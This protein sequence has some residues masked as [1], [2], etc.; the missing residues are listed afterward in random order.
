MSTA[1]ITLAPLRPARDLAAV[2]AVYRRAGDYLALE[3]GLT[4]AAAAR[5][6]F[7]ERPPAGSDEPM[8]FGI[9]GE[10]GL[11]AIGDLAFGYPQPDDAFIGLLLLV[12]EWRGAGL[13]GAI[14]AEVKRLALARGAS[15]LLVG[16]LDA[17]ARA[18]VFWERQGF[19]LTQTSG[20]LAFGERRHV[21]HRLELPL[22]NLS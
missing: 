6:F 11:L 2:E 9:A 4:P 12:P 10:D 8:K 16:V 19:R 3:S 22:E 20:P 1:T 18:R 5:A 14:V 15:R 21:V 13:G 17:N 7:E